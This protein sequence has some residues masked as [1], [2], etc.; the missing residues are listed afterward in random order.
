MPLRQDQNNLALSPW[1]MPLTLR[2]EIW[3][4]ITVILI[5]A[6]RVPVNPKSF[7]LS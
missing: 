5:G 4:Q 1:A 7:P 6:H 2:Q 3:S